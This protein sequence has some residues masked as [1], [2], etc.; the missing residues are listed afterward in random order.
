MKRWAVF[1]FLLLIL[2]CF[3]KA[4]LTLI[5]S[6]NTDTALSVDV[7]GSYAYVVDHWF[8]LRIIN[9]TNP[10]SPVEVGSFND[11]VASY[12]AAVS[13]SYA[14]VVCNYWNKYGRHYG[15]QI[16]NI[17][18]P[19]S[20]VPVGF[21]DIPGSMNALGRVAISG[22][23][24]YVAA[25]VS[26]LQIINIA[27]PVSPVLVGSC[28]TLGDARDVAI[29]G[30]Y[31]YV[32]TLYGS[33]LQV[34]NIA[35]PASPVIVG[36]WDQQVYD[37]AVTVYGS[38]AYVESRGYLN[39]I[40]IANPAS[41]VLVGF[42]RIYF[43]SDLGRVA[44][45]GNY[46]YV[47]DRNSGLWIIDISNSSSPNEVEFYDTPG[48]AIDVSVSGEY[49]YLADWTSLQ[50]LADVTCI[51]GYKNDTFGN[52]LEGWTIFIDKDGDGVLDPGEPSNTTDS[53]GH[54]QICGLL[55]GD[56]VNV[57][58]VAEADWAPF[59][60]ATGR[61]TVTVQPNNGT[62]DINFTN[63]Y[64][65][66]LNEDLSVSKVAQ[67]NGITV[68]QVNPGQTFNYNITVTNKDLTNDAPLVVVT[69]KLPYDVEYIETEVYPATPLDYT[70]NQSDDLVYARFNQI[71][72][73]STRY[74]NITA[75]APIQAPTTLY[76]IVNLRYRDDQNLTDNRMTLATYV[77][78]PG[79]N[80][81]EAAKS[82]EDLLHNQS[83]LLFQFEDLLH[84][85]P[86]NDSM[87][88]TFLVSFEQLL[89]S[90][91]DLTSSFEDLLTNESST[92]WDTEYTEENR[93]KLLWSYE[94]M[95]YDE[96]FLFASFNMKIN[97]SWM[98]LCDYSA[99]GHTQD[100]QTE[101]IASFEDLLKRQTRL[102][103]SFNLLLKKIDITSNQAMIDFLAA[104]EN[105]LRVEAN[106][107]MSFNDMLDT[108]YE[109]PICP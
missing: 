28:D 107:L 77:A 91:A 88:Y 61:Q 79:Y 32:A 56:S 101:L 62:N 81:T 109:N 13:G 94:Q 29:S 71:P 53:N 97:D 27:N 69:D 104:Y 36:N 17:A 73:G 34:I 24:A 63:R 40:N 89:R 42:Y 65:Q 106:L 70:I 6:I 60:P 87:N 7:S 105:L 99:D 48:S 26:G 1:V 67:V 14:Y 98:S 66:I 78:Q 83:Q 86:N 45:S 54:W 95:L 58:E 2:P 64:G 52:K 49:A 102:Y 23:Y 74:I 33:G 19:A 85:I 43:W 100:A 18:N 3:A 68:Q 82:F 25:S 46:A 11:L 59:D 39:I 16:I 75:K 57:T 51:D 50:I 15:L 9:I 41:P 103:K 37:H 96:A 12:D 76:N 31:A 84:T 22:D 93:T 72:A 30:D 108:K 47:A 44:I 35:N 8:G 4:E 92:G 55:A 38:Y 90:Q 10:A 20:P 21:C 80:Q 5:G